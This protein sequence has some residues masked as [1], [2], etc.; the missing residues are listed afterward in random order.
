M[1]SGVGG[2]TWS[3]C[4]NLDGTKGC[5]GAG[6][7][8]LVEGGVRRGGT[9]RLKPESSGSGGRVEEI[10]RGLVQGVGSPGVGESA[11]LDVT[12]GCDTGAVLPTE[13]G[14]AALIRLAEGDL[15]L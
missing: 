8:Y 12:K 11:D 6:A 14:Q 1:R 10:R 5:D 2:V 4:A 9:G 3:R 15:T 13:G 7:V